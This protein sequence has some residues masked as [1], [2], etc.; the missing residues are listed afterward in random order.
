MFVL[1]IF[2]PKSEKIQFVDQY[3]HAKRYKIDSLAVR[4]TYTDVNPCQNCRTFVIFRVAFDS[5]Y[6]IMEKINGNVGLDRQKS[7]CQSSSTG[8]LLCGQGRMLLAF[9]KMRD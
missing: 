6:K 3:A 4:L 9:S 1:N 2:N 7:S 8:P 5:K